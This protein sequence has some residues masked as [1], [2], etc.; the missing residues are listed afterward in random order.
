MTNSGQGK[1][2]KEFSVQRKANWFDD[3][4]SAFL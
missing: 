2:K 4:K 1:P 3:Q